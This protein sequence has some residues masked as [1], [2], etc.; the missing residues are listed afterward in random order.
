[1]MITRL[2]SITALGTA[3]GAILAT[4]AAAAD[5]TTRHS[6]PFGP[7]EVIVVERVAGAVTGRDDAGGLDTVEPVEAFW[8]RTVHA[9]EALAH[10]IANLEPGP[11]RDAMA[12]ALN[13]VFSR[14]DGFE[15]PIDADWVATWTRFRGRMDAS[16]FDLTEQ[17]DAA[18]AAGGPRPAVH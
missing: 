13:G 4:A 16:L 14:L 5:D 6:L 8:L 17:V 10:D 2:A 18:L 3:L 1:M 7:E 9:A 15:A 12:A 11:H